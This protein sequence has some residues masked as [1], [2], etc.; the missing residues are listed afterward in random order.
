MDIDKAQDDEETEDAA[1][2]KVGTILQSC[3]YFVG[4]T[5]GRLS[6]YVEFCAAP[7]DVIELPDD[8]EEVP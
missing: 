7:N 1:T 4:W 5:V 8:D 6:S 3:A 2:S